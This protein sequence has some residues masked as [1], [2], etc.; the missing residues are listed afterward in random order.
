[1]PIDNKKSI[2]FAKNTCHFDQREKSPANTNRFLLSV[3]MTKK[4]NIMNT[5]KSLILLKVCCVCFLFN[6]CEPPV[7][8]PEPPKPE[9]PVEFSI[10]GYLNI[11]NAVLIEAYSVLGVDVPYVVTIASSEVDNGNFKITLPDT[12]TTNL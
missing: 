9:Q 10:D 4:N 12:L 6:S 3:E 5:K 7:V 8:P 2:I 1:M 11:P